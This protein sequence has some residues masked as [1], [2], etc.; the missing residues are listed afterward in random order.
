[1]GRGRNHDLA[2]LHDPLRDTSGN[3]EG[4][5]GGGNR[6][7][8]GSRKFRSAGRGNWRSEKSKVKPMAEFCRVKNNFLFHFFFNFFVN[9]LKFELK[10]GDNSWAVELLIFF[11]FL[12]LH[13]WQFGGGGDFFF[14]KEANENVEQKVGCRNYGVGVSTGSGGSVKLRKKKKL[15]RRK[16][17]FWGIIF[18]TVQ[19]IEGP[20]AHPN[21]RSSSTN[22]RGDR[23]R[24]NTRHWVVAHRKMKRRSHA[25]RKWCR[26]WYKMEEIIIDNY[27]KK[28]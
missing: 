21:L 24:R 10:E 19:T 7:R 6:G 12:V 15:K 14:C 4:G 5:G 25:H 2:A 18:L 9:S 1:V 20:T 17:D 13:G 16:H 8:T 27:E 11:F 26:K 23:K 22:Q 28:K 3:G